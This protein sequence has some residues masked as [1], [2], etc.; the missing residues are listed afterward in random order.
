M[1]SP[2]LLGGIVEEPPHP[3]RVGTLRSIGIMAGPHAHPQLLQRRQRTRLP[4]FIDDGADRPPMPIRSLEEID[5]VDA[6]R[7]VCL[8]HLPVLGPAVAF[9]VLAEPSH[10]I[11]QWLVRRRAGQEPPHPAHDVGSR[12][13]SCQLG[14][15]QELAKLLQSRLEL[16]HVAPC[17][18][19]TQGA[20]RNDRHTI[21]QVQQHVTRCI[22][23][24]PPVWTS[25]PVADLQPGL[26]PTWKWRLPPMLGF[27]GNW[28][29]RQL[30]G[31]SCRRVEANRTG[32]STCPRIEFRE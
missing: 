30:P 22:D 21:L 25:T 18:R 19:E 5:E 9:Q 12:R 2:L 29:R 14:L 16:A 15:E 6:E 24:E 31:S 10:L 13:R 8:T 4:V 26:P 23:T 32:R 28:R 7:L 20:C 27:P 17:L 11:R 3:V 1:G